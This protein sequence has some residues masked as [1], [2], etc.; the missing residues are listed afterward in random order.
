MKC[1]IPKTEKANMSSKST[2]QS[3]SFMTSSRKSKRCLEEENQILR[4]KL[5]NYIEL[6]NEKLKEDNEELYNK[7]Q[8]ELK[9]R[10]E[11][12]NKFEELLKNYT[13]LEKENEELKNK[14]NAAISVPVAPVPTIEV[15]GELE[16]EEYISDGNNQGVRS[17]G[18]GQPANHR[19]YNQEENDYLTSICLKLGA[20]EKKVR[21]NYDEIYKKFMKTDKTSENFK[22]LKTETGRARIKFDEARKNFNGKNIITLFKSR[23]ANA[24]RRQDVHL[25]QKITRIK[26]QLRK[27]G[28]LDIRT[29]PFYATA[30]AIEFRKSQKSK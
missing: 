23:F 26:T 1:I 14:S 29:K 17:R 21:E 5:T 11:L 20:E 2:F 28:K 30:E 27:D 3:Q 7:L 8:E 15:N 6:E 16:E 22:T 13:I 19:P 4:E 12:C 24:K 10:Q 25:Q 18:T 9:K